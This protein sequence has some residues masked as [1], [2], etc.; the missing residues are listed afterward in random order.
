MK[1]LVFAVL[2]AASVTAFG[3]SVASAQMTDTHRMESANARMMHRQHMSRHHH[4]K[5]HKMHRR[6]MMRRKMGM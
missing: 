4:M 6:H 5:R 3:S 2:C 1:K